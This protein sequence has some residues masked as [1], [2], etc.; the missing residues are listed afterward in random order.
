LPRTVVDAAVAEAAVVGNELEARLLAGQ[1]PYQY[2]NPAQ[3]QI[4]KDRVKALM[5]RSWTLEG[6]VLWTC[7]VCHEDMKKSDLEKHIQSSCLRPHPGVDC[8]DCGNHYTTQ[9]SAK[10]HRAKKDGGCKPRE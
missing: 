5:V 6:G 10:V 4:L 8:S 7:Y 1:L 9:E 3:M 2:N